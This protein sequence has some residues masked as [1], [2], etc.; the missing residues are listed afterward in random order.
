MTRSLGDFYLQRFGVSWV[1]EVITVD[2]HVSGVP[3]PTHTRPGQRARYRRPIDREASLCPSRARPAPTLSPVQEV[4]E[5]LHNL[6]LVL[7]SDGV[8]DLWEYGPAFDA[9]VQPEAPDGP[10]A[11]VAEA[12]ASAFFR[13]SLAKGAEIFGETADNMT[14]IVVYLVQASQG[15]EASATKSG[16]R[17]AV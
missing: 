5:D 1:P 12:R 9:I 4:G 17:L 16:G 15:G 10:L 13:H 2:L 3:T 8:W 11:A 6:T 7:A 14:G